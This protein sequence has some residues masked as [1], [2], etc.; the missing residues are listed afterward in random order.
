MVDFISVLLFMNAHDDR[1][2]QAEPRHLIWINHDVLVIGDMSIALLS[3]SLHR[4]VP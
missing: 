3:T 1:I 4:G 2:A